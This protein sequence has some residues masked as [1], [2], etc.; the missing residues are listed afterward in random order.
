MRDELLHLITLVPYGNKVR[1]V[2]TEIFTERKSLTRSEFYSAYQVGLK[3]KYVF[4]ISPDDY[5]MCKIAFDGKE[6]YPTRINYRGQDYN[7]LRI[8]SLNSNS[9]EITAG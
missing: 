4:E 7:I 8:F 6:L 9:M 2:K 5:E 3:G 1:E